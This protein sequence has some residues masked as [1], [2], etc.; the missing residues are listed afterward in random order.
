MT[1]CHTN[2]SI[3][4]AYSI[5][6]TPLNISYTSVKN[7]GFILTR[8]LFPNMHIQQICYKTLKLLGFINRV[9]TEFKRLSPLNIFYFFLVHFI[10]K[11]DNVL[12]N[13]SFTSTRNVIEMVQRK[14]LRHVPYKLNIHCPPHDYSPV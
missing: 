3:P 2:S 10:L 1:F 7:L 14:F 8:N 4:C 12:W 6:N 5:N 9:S 11:Y 13:P